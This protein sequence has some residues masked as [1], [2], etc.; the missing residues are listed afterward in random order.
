MQQLMQTEEDMLLQLFIGETQN[1]STKEAS[2]EM[3]QQSNLYK[4]RMKASHFLLQQ[5]KGTSG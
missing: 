3:I 5:K 4:V 2:E 1:S